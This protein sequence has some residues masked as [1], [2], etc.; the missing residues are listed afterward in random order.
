MNQQSNKK[1]NAASRPFLPSYRRLLIL[2]V[3]SL[4]ALPARAW[5]DQ[6]INPV[7]LIQH[8]VQASDIWSGGPIR[9]RLAVVFFNVKAAKIEG[10]YEKL[11]I[12]PQRW[13]AD[14]K[15]AE[16]NDTTVGGDS[17]AWHTADNPEK[18]LRVLQFERALGAL[19]Q[20]FVQSPSTFSFTFHERGKG[21]D[22]V[23]CVE[24]TVN[25]GSAVQDCVDPATGLFRAVTEGNWTFLFSDY[26]EFSKKMFPQTVAVVDGLT[27][28][29]TARVVDL[30]TYSD[31]KPELFQP[32]SGAESYKVCPPALGLPLGG[33]GGKLLKG[34]DPSWPNLSP[35]Y[36]SLRKSG[37][38]ADRDLLQHLLQMNE[39]G[40]PPP[41]VQRPFVSCNSGLNTVS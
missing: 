13:R 16:F 28:A 22:K 36:Q 21:A 19:S 25:H 41:T 3:L 2:A 5:D 9:L 34:P 37:G 20:T 31:E 24:V 33:D 15:S 12:S 30:E 38:V 8:A 29:V 18:P 39:D 6:K 26:R 11:W 23:N 4:S 1:A 17:R 14:F 40:A 35:P 10:E 7:E 32:L 27:V